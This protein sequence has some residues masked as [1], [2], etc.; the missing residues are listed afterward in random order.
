MALTETWTD[1]GTTVAIPG[2]RQITQ[3]K[4]ETVKAGGV[5]IY[6]NEDYLRL[7]AGCEL[8]LRREIPPNVCG[9]I[10]S[11]EVT[12][13]GTQV[14]LV[15]LYIS[16]GSRLQNIKEF[17]ELNL[18]AYSHKT[19]SLK[20]VASRNLDKIAIMLVGD[21]NVNL[22]SGYGQQLLQFLDDTWN[23]KINN[24]ISLPTTKGSTCIDAVFSR[25]MNQIKTLNYVSYFSYHNPLLSITERG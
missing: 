10:C 11:A 25:N 6:E 4:R 23:L 20:Y 9:D 2:F 17:L 1:D 21:L 19:N 12:I 22:T 14:L 24:D 3:P 8:A 7:A 5:A 16:P 18:W 13:D 15:A